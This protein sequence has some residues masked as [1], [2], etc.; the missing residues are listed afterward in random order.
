MACFETDEKQRLRLHAGTEE[1]F[2]IAN[3]IL[4]MCWFDSRSILS[5]V[6]G[7]IVHRAVDIVSIVWYYLI[8]S[9]FVRASKQ[10]G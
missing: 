1:M 5:F 4:Y 2:H 9:I 10:Q 8:Q 3:D 6:G 7:Q